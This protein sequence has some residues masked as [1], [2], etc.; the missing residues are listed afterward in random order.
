MI[1]RPTP[2]YPLCQAAIYANVRV[3]SSELPDDFQEGTI[4]THTHLQTWTV[5]PAVRL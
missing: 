2:A 3:R 1:V 4:V 5:R